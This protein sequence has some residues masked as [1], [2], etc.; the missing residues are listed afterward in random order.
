MTEHAPEEIIEETPAQEKQYS[1]PATQEEL[2]A[3]IESR[4]YKERKKY[5]DHSEL[6]K[7][8]SAYDELQEA[9]KTELEKA[10]ARAEK[11][12]AEANALKAA[13]ELATMRA[14]VA[15]ESGVP[16]EVLRGDSLEELQAHAAALKTLIVANNGVPVVL[17]DGKQA[18][19]VTGNT[20]A[21]FSAAL[22][23]LI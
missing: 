12:E 8:A 18:T 16:A 4:L 13:Q 6:Q 11:A 15:H 23:G 2:N 21:Q 17:T 3:I 9:S 20:A 10:Q 14:D 22:D 1:A 5:S 7:K 19:K